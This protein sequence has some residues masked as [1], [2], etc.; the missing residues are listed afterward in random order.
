MSD[1]LTAAAPNK[2]GRAPTRAPTFVLICEIR[3]N[4]L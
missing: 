1:D 2:A 3:F 4:G